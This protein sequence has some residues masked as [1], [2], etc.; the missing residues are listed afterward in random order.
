MIGDPLFWLMG[1]AFVLGFVLGGVVVHIIAEERAA[2]RMQMLGGGCPVCG[3]VK[4][5]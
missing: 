2:L 5:V 4:K 1:V 3:V